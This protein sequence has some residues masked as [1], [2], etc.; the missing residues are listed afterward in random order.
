MLAEMK[1][2][3]LLTLLLALPLCFASCDD[4]KIQEEVYDISGVSLDITSAELAIGDTV[5]ISVTVQPYGVPPQDIKWSD[6]EKELIEWRTDNPDVATVSANGVVTAVNKGTC[7]VTFICG[8]YAAKCTVI[9][10]DFN[11]ESIFGQWKSAGNPDYFFNFDGTGKAGDADITWLFDGMRITIDSAGVT[12]T[13]VVVSTD[14]GLFNCYDQ[15]DAEKTS[16]RMTLTPRP[17]TADDLSH[18]LIQVD[19]KNGLKFDA[20]DLGLPGGVLWSTCNLLAQEPQQSGGFYSWGEV[21]T[22]QDYTLENYKWYDTIKLEL[23]G[24]AGY[25]GDYIVNLDLED[26]AANSVMGGDWRM[27]TSHDFQVLCQNTFIVWS[28][29]GD[30]EGLMFVSRSYGRNQNAIFLP[31]AGLQEDYYQ[32]VAAVSEQI[33]IYWT[34]TLSSSNEYYAHYLHISNTSGQYLYRTSQNIPTAMRFSG[35]CIRPVADQHFMK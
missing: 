32:H 18:N 26:D 25:E 14:T 4:D 2:R 13:F 7:T 24:Y 17:I 9:V 21:E 1:T 27:P 30:T 5:A 15:S 6:E 33:G 10:R 34:S 16:F 29:L 19:G 31:F 8:T 20:V 23:T 22:K 35:A 3:S 28:K 11:I 12:K